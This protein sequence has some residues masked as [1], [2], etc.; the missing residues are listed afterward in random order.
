MVPVADTATA[1]RLSFLG[2]PTVRVDGR[3]VDPEART[4]SGWSMVCRVYVDSGK[5]QGF[6]PKAMVAKAI[7]EAAGR[8]IKL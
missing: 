4:M 8:Q 7:S 1:Q 2:S 6:P 3:D 5:P